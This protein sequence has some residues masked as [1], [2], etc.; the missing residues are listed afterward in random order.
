M[1]QLDELVEDLNKASDL[2]FKIQ[3]TENEID[4]LIKRVNG[5]VDKLV[6]DCNTVEE[7][8]ELCDA[9]GLDNK[10]YRWG[11]EKAYKN[12]FEEDTDYEKTEWSDVIY[13]VAIDLRLFVE[14][15]ARE[16]WRMNHGQ[17]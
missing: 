10:G 12:S 2:Q 11:W 7:L 6:Y 4:K 16:K 5:K 13:H 3:S 8:S 14:K 17:N 1:T 15:R 9:F